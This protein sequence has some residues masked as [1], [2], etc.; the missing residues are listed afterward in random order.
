MEV[1]NASRTIR[2]KLN[3]Q[4]CSI[5]SNPVTR[6]S[7][8]L[9]E[10]LGLTGTKVGCDAGDCGACTILI[11][12]EQRFACLTAAGQLEGCDVQ[13]KECGHRGGTLYRR[14]RENLGS[15]SGI[16]SRRKF[17]RGTD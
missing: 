11:D 2:F 10:E 15:R 8:V 6:T 5:A 9:R 13:T 3:G 4:G 12:G 16:H 1:E 14:Y 7:D 17:T